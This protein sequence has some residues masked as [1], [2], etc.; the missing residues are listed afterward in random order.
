MENRNP[1]VSVLPPEAGAPSRPP[2]EARTWAMLCHL[3]GLLGYLFPLA[4]IFGPLVVWLLKGERYP[5]V[6]DQGKEAMNFQITF[7][8]Y[9][10][11]AGL[12]VL[13]VIGFALLGILVVFHFIVVI[14]AAVRAKGGEAYRYPLTIRF[15]K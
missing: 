8:I 15:I 7:S 6:D 11:L 1:E 2:A 5:L 9:F 12:L 14:V 13:I 4:H 10:L 3:S